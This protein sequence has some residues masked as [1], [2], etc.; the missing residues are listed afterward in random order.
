MVV[1]ILPCT[2]LQQAKIHID[3]LRL[4]AI[5]YEHVMLPWQW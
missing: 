3:C 5:G 1:G 2:V 4:V